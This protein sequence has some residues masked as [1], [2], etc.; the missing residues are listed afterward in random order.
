MYNYQSWFVQEQ[1]RSDS[2]ITWS[3]HFRLV[4]E[5]AAISTRIILQNNLATRFTLLDWLTTKS[6]TFVQ[7][8]DN[9][10]VIYV[11]TSV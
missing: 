4:Q 5:K 11:I 1:L 3:Q 7:T 8:E 10:E 2:E 6:P 9:K